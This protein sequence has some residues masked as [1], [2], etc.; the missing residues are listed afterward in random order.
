MK[1]PPLCTVAVRRHRPHTEA[2]MAEK[3]AA[4]E[5]SAPHRPLG[6]FA[7]PYRHAN[8]RHQRDEDPITGCRDRVRHGRP[9]PCCWPADCGSA[10]YRRPVPPAAGRSSRRAKTPS[11]RW[12]M[13]S[14]AQQ[15]PKTPTRE[16][17]TRRSA[18]RRQ[19]VAVPIAIR[20][21]H[22][23]AAD[24][25]ASAKRASRRPARSRGSSLLYRSGTRLIGPPATL[26]RCR[27]RQLTKPS[28]PIVR[29]AADLVHDPASRTTGRFQALFPIP[30]GADGNAQKTREDPLTARSRRRACLTNWGEYFRGSTFRRTVRQVNRSSILSVFSSASVN[31]RQPARPIHDRWTSSIVTKMHGPHH[32]RPPG[33]S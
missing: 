6:Q 16:N 27:N 31:L 9:P 10:A 5:R 32:V 33:R 26:T 23:I 12:C 21:V 2:A 22:V 13:P 19:V 3:I 30:D 1:V 20:D 15:S 7:E 29:V 4:D 28:K 24:Q 11:P 17:P 18:R 25:R 14:T 8:H